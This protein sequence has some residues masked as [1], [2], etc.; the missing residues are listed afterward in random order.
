MHYALQNITDLWNLPTPANN[1]VDDAFDRHINKLKAAGVQWHQP[2]E[3]G[4]EPDYSI[5]QKRSRKSLFIIS[6]AAALLMVAQ[7]IMV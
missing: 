6:I 7:R 3:A 5:S 4:L 1:D 2:Q